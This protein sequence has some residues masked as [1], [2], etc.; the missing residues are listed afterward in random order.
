MPKT[1]YAKLSMTFLLVLLLFLAGFIALMLWSSKLYHLEVT[2]RLNSSLAMY[3]AGAKPLIT[4]GEVQQ[5]T[6]EE[7]AHMVMI[8]NPAVEVYLLDLQGNI[9]ANALPEGSVQ[10][11]QIDLAPLNHFIN[12]SIPFPSLGT[13]PRQ[14][15]DQK[16]FSAS[17]VEDTATHNHAGYL[18]IVLAGEAYQNLAQSLANSHILRNSIIAMILAASFACLCAFI[19]FSTITRPLRH[20]TQRMIGFQNAELTAVANT[21]GSGHHIDQGDEITTL[22]TVFNHMSNL[23]HEQIAALGEVDRVRRELIS[24]VSH[25]LRTPI[26]SMQ[27]YLETM[28][29]KDDTLTDKQKKDYT[30]IAYKHGQHLSRL[31]TELFELTKLESGRVQ[32]NKEAFSLAELC[33]DISQK[34]T[35]KLQQKDIQL[36]L[37]TQDQHHW[38]FADIALIERV[39]ENLIENAI[40][41][42][43]KQ[44]HIELILENLE[45]GVSVRVSDS[46]HG[47]EAQE[48]SRIFDRYYQCNTTPTMDSSTNTSK[49]QGEQKLSSGGLGLAIVKRILELHNS[50][51]LVQS[52][53]NKG[54]SFSFPLPSPMSSHT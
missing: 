11:G 21:H 16:I 31:V 17:I 15:E 51:I 39:L 3:V 25:D 12:G 27:G 48:L 32:A 34:F 33:H 4:H 22:N 29:L 5:Q 28:M 50:D 10:L 52:E 42:T 9:L 43:P 37:N 45:E 19:L 35:L 53:P 38:V 40:R 20:L 26:A 14:P 1:L 7:L 47:M 8:V 41:Y 44:G 49:S 46:G 6:I 2:Q 54:T 18:Y 24:N 23:I 30:N 13:D 36:Q